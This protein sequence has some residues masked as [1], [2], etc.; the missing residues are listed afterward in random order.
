MNV[1][2]SCQPLEGAVFDVD[3]V[4]AYCTVCPLP[5]LDPNS[6]T[7]M[8]V[9]DGVTLVFIVGRPLT[10]APATLFTVNVTLKLSENPPLPVPPTVTVA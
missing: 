6:F 3:V 4:I 9:D 10:A 7:V 8:L 5:V 1:G 2:L